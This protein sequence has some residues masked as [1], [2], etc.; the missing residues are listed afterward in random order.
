MLAVLVG[1]DGAH[2]VGT[3]GQGR[4]LRLVTEGCNQMIDKLFVVTWILGEMR[5]V[6][7]MLSHSS[8][9]VESRLGVVLGIMVSGLMHRRG[10]GSLLSCGSMVL[11]SGGEVCKSRVLKRT[12]VVSLGAQEVLVVRQA[13]H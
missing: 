10:Y 8:S 3:G 7:G 5:R 1:V 12:C 6:S 4:R 2:A 9:G 11:V 13:R